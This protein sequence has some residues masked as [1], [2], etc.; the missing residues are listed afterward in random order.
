MIT[1][2]SD[3]VSMVGDAQPGDNFKLTVYRRGQT[4]ELELTVGEKVQN[5]LPDTPQ[6]QQPDQ[7][8][9][10]WGFMP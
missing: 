3:L 10:P 2:S 7:N 5:A 9:Y 8:N 1:G 4:L 6:T